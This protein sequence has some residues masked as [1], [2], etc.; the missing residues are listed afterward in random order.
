V[1]SKI[2]PITL[3]ADGRDL[4]EQQP[5]ETTRRFSQFVAY[6]DLGET[7]TL[8]KAAATL[9]L[10]ASYL[11][12]VSAA[13]Q[14]G[15]RTRAWDQHV[16][17]QRRLELL[18]QSRKAWR[19][20]AQLLALA[21]GKVTQR[22]ARLDPAELEP[23]DLARMLDTI[24]KHRRLL[25]G[26]PTEHVQVSGPDGGPVELVEFAQLPPEVRQARLLEL[27][28]QVRQRAEAAAGALDGD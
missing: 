27:A 2:K 15:R 7:R 19:Q 18:E 28:E 5:G 13:G 11:R 4:W 12:D 20:D 10:S 21:L 23:R 14:W 9:A 25:H 26:G 22:I 6:R 1:A 16:D 17:R 24:L 3:A 8:Q